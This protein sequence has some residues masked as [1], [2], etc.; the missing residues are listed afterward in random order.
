M[1]EPPEICGCLT[2]QEANTGSTDMQMHRWV[3]GSNGGQLQLN[4]RDLGSLLGCLGVKSLANRRYSSLGSLP[5]PRRCGEQ[6]LLQGD[7]A[8]G[9][10]SIRCCA[11]SDAASAGLQQPVWCSRLVP[12]WWS[13]TPR[14][15]PGE[16]SPSLLDEQVC[17]ACTSTIPVYIACVGL[18]QPQG[19]RAVV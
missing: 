17:D 13:S 11:P 12:C 18:F 10:S 7:A 3:R 2:E 14:P 6:R 16:G 4:H 9:P 19:Q 8:A 1:V 15:A 5:K